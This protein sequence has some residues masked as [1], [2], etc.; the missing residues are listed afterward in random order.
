MS[1]VKDCCGSFL[2]VEMLVLNSWSILYGFVSV[3]CCTLGLILATGAIWGQVAK[4]LF[5]FSL[6]LGNKTIMELLLTIAVCT[7]TLVSC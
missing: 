2:L 6:V 3:Y 5:P 4:S 1:G 7:P